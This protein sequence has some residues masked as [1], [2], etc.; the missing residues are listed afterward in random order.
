MQYESDAFVVAISKK[1]LRTNYHGTFDSHLEVWLLAGMVHATITPSLPVLLFLVGVCL[2]YQ[3]P[4]LQQADSGS[5]HRQQRAV[6]A[7]PSTRAH[8]NPTDA[9]TGPGGERLPRTGAVRCSSSFPASLGSC[10]LLI[11]PLFAENLV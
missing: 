4:A 3:E 2:L 6:R 7:T 1:Q 9:L 10:S 8:R 5:V 11:V